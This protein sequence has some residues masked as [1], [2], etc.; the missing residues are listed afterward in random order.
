MAKFESFAG[1]LLRLEGGYVNHP[2]DRGGPTKYGVILSVWQEHG[3]D[4]DGDGDIDA[5][6][7]KKL[8]EGDAKYIAKKIFWDYF[9]ADLI[10][11][12]S[13]AEFI[14]DWGYNSGRKTVAKIVQRVVKATVDGIV[15]PQTV[16]AINC[17]DQ[18]LLFNA[19]KIE[20]KVFLN[21]IIKRRPDQIVFYDGW[22]NR[23]NSF[24]YKAA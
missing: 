16:T 13:L 9:L 3:H 20:R 14:V 12:Q 18:E 8:S 6:D 24:N 17:A 5:E 7:I 11:N 19:L 15:G 2:L 1:K 10:L 4:K 22:M 23:V 21:A